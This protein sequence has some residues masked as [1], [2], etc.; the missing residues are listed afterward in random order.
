MVDRGPR[1]F[2][3]LRGRQEECETLLDLVQTARSGHSAVLVVRGEA[4]IG[5]TALVEYL[6]GAASDCRR[7]R[8]PHAEIPAARTG[9]IAHPNPDQPFPN[10]GS[11]TRM[12]RRRRA[13]RPGSR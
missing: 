3:P 7:N 11:A 12:I 13:E 9:P 1:P 6:A 5:K 2:R 8:T 4:G 10:R